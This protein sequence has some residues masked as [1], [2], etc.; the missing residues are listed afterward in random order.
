MLT[1]GGSR[2]VLQPSLF[3]HNYKWE[4]SSHGSRWRG[5]GLERYDNL[6][7][8]KVTEPAGRP[9]RAGCGGL[10]RLKGN[11]QRGITVLDRLYPSK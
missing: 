7:S 2:A 4:A 9:S 10:G 8:A 3:A 5:N 1:S 11:M 6:L